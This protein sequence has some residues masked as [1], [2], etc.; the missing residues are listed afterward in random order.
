MRNPQRMPSRFSL[1]TQQ[2]TCLAIYLSII[3]R[4]DR[5]TIFRDDAWRKPI[6]ILALTS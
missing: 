4:E 2:K 3:F 1:A 6:P 5:K